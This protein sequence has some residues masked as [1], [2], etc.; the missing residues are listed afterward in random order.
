MTEELMRVAGMI[1][2]QE[3]PI[4]DCGKDE[5]PSTPDIVE[6]KEADQMVTP[7]ATSSMPARTQEDENELTPEQGP[8]D[9]IKPIANQRD[10][11]LDATVADQKIKY[12]NDVE[13]LNTGRQETDRM[14]DLLCQE[15][16]QKRPRTYRHTARK[17]FLRF[18]K[19]KTQPRNIIRKARR[20]QLHYLKRNLKQLDWLIT[21]YQSSKQITA[22]I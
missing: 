15:L 9:Q 22:S 7:K 20:Q 8:V 21:K 12:P 18:A 16:E 14:I 6:G 10:M 5:N 1:E 3:E 13:L 11:Q 2:K 19:R 4:H 17:Q